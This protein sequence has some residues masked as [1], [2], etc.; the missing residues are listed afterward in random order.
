MS[1][2][3][4]Y[5]SAADVSANGR[6]WL[7][8]WGEPAA[9]Y[10]AQVL[11]TPAVSRPFRIADAPELTAPQVETSGQDCLV[12]WQSGASTLGRRV[13]TLKQIGR[14]VSVATDSAGAA[15][16]SLGGFAGNGTRFCVTGTTA[17]VNASWLYNDVWF[18]QFGPG[19]LP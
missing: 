8:V 2:S 14:V 11:R 15:Y 1:S 10:G 5:S 13:T 9:I 3:N 12:L 17:P 4:Q 18:G 7:V 19:L 6:G 16:F